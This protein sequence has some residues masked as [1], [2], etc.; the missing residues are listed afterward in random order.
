[1]ARG[2]RRGDGTPVRSMGGKWEERYYCTNCKRQFGSKRSW[3]NHT[4]SIFG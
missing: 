4:V 2:C 3:F 1:M